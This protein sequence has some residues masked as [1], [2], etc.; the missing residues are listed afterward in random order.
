MRSLIKSEARL[1]QRQMRC[2]SERKYALGLALQV[3]D[4][5]RALIGLSRDAN[6]SNGCDASRSHSADCSSAVGALLALDARLRPQLAT[7]AT[8]FLRRFLVVVVVV[9]GVGR[10]SDRPTDRATVGRLVNQ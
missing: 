5:L 3:V 6:E 8:T 9:V 7:T 10:P 4:A 2:S 1:Q